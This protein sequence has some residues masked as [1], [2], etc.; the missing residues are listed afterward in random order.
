V[1]HISQ[2]E[3]ELPDLEFPEIFRRIS[4]NKSIISLGPGQPDFVTPKPLL[5]Y[6]KK[7]IRK[8]SRYTEPQGM[9]ELRK[10]ICKK[11]KKE[12]KIIAE[13]ENVILGCG[14]QETLFA[15]LLSIIDPTNQVIVPSPGY[16]GYIPAIE[17]V[18]GVP[19]F[20]K[21]DEEDEFEINP[22][23]IKKLI[24]KKK[25][26]AIIINS[27]ANPTGNVLSKKTLEELADISVEHDLVIFSDEAYEQLTYEKKHVSIAS[28]NGLNSVPTFQTFSKSFSMCGFRLGY[29]VGNEKLIS[30]INKV[31]HYITLSAPHISQLIAV[32]ALTLPKK[33][34]NSMVKEYKKRRNFIVKKLNEL[35]MPTPMPQGAFYTFS[36]IQNYNKNSVKFQRLLMDK[37]K[38]AGIPGT[39]F[40]PYGEGYIRFSYATD[41]NLI[42]KAMERIEKFL[43]KI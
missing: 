32:K 25:T 17:L 29:V 12:N 43:N 6:A 7:I 40:G 28:L 31:H 34:V 24:D 9:L 39:E 41:Y 36:N 8:S 33:Y 38:V 5:D 11:L 2:R 27:P 13:P 16:L 26:K 3:S 37:A 10:S 42:V 19:V 14:S 35:N 1:V 22:D 15:S 21:I 23:R 18:N 30:A 20:I 4:R